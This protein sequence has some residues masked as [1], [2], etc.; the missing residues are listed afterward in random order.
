MQEGRTIACPP[1]LPLG[2]EVYIPYF[3]QTFVCEDRGGAIKGRR[4]DVYMTSRKRAL[5]FGRRTLPVEIR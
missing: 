1:H 4:L 2:T 5:Q 3:G